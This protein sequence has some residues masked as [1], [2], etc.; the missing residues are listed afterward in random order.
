MQLALLLCA[1]CPATGQMAHGDVSPSAGCAAPRC[2]IVRTAI[3][4]ETLP[5]APLLGLRIYTLMSSSLRTRIIVLC[6]AI[7]VCAMALIATSNFWMTRDST[8]HLVQ[9]QANQLA[10][11]E[12]DALSAW[13]LAKQ[14]VVA[15]LAPHTAAQDRVS[16]LKTAVQ[17]GGFDQAYMGY[18]DRSYVFSENRA[19]R[20]ADYDPT[21]R[22]WYKGALA[23]NGAS[24]TEPFI[25]ATT[26]KLIITFSQLVGSSSQVQAVVAGDVLLESVIEDIAAI[27][28]T[29]NSYAFLLSGRGTIV[30]HPQRDLVLQPLS[31]LHPDLTLPKLTQQSEDLEQHLWQLQGRE[32][33]VLTQA[34]AGTPWV[35]AVVMDHA[36]VTA[37]L[38]HMLTLSLLVAVAVCALATALLFWSIRQTLLRLD[39]VRQA[40]HA[41][42]DGNFS[43][44]L[45]VQG[46]DEL[47][48]MAHA[49]NRF[50]DNIAQVLYRMRD[51]SHSVEVAAS[52]IAAGNQ[53]LSERTEQQAD[54]LAQ[55]V[56]S[57][58]QL[59]NNVQLNAQ[60]A[61][62][63]NS[64]AQTAS[65]VA[66][67]GGTVVH[68]VVGV[69]Q[70]INQASLR[71]ADIIG[72]IDS[73]AF[74]TN[75]LALNAAVEA[76]RAGEQGRGFAVVASEVRQ[77]AQ[78]SATAAHEIKQLIDN[79]VTKVSS[80]SALVQ[81]AGQTMQ[82]IVHSVQS[83]A[84]IMG[85]IS[86]ASQSQSQDIAHINQVVN[87][88]ESSTQQNTALV[89]EAAAAAASLR[90]QAR[91]LAQM[92]SGFTLQEAHAAALPPSFTAPASASTSTASAAPAL[93]AR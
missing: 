16:V 45:Q 68:G 29:P 67:K 32:G 66:H 14:R 25:G 44:R 43:Q 33:Y 86:H 60:N 26:Q 38:Q 24:M 35:L 83:V 50:A 77:L 19:G 13:L 88:M 64:L 5:H 85:E 55:T 3:T 80:G 15:S 17:A 70:E 12:A 39:A 59:T 74:Q 11:A 76:A 53:N 28:P 10:K 31:A 61:N 54:H 71:M 41:A 36:E 58:D 72:V 37:P 27:R 87:N 84:A 82:E 21:Q 65:A 7:V 9:T 34:I 78:R 40:I 62:R 23:A 51:S 20:A 79:S 22:A 75:I 4:V 48:E 90:E 73:I 52:E 93:P 8:L 63:A 6:V 18:P 89:E 91:V 2:T 47:S 1:I 92:V 69:M 81:E 30:A 42:G 46:K 56:V 49:Y 57:V